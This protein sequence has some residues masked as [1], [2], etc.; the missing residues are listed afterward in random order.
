MAMFS[1]AAPEID[2]GTKRDVST[3]YGGH[4]NIF[5]DRKTML[6][7]ATGKR[8]YHHGIYKRKKNY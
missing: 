8:K 6:E 7:W 2:T 5:D 1:T 3:S 4:I